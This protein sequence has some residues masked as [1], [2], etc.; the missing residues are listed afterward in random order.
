MFNVLYQIVDYLRQVL[1]A[2]ARIEA[3]LKQILT[4]QAGIQGAIAALKGDISAIRGDLAAQRSVLEQ[5]LDRL[6]PKPATRIVFTVHLNGETRAGVDSMTIKDNQEFDVTL[7]FTDAGGNPA[8]VDGVPQWS[9]DNTTALTVTPAADGMSAVVSAN[10]PVGTGQ[11]TVTADADLGTGTTTITGV[12]AVEVLAGD[13][14]VI[15]LNPGEVREQGA[16]PTP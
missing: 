15:Q 4:G 11:V 14:T 9:V 6:T 2:Q 7:S 5:I 8:S 1:K 3:A 13:A 12:L 16:G 10:G